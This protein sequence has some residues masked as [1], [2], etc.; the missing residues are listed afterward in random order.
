M[1]GNPMKERATT[2]DKPDQPKPE[3]PIFHTVKEAA[4]YLRLCDKQIR[5]LISRGELPAYRFGMAFRIKKE[6]IDAYAEAR[7]IRPP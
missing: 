1:G 2:S 7:R 4:T 6:D 3:Q 5:R